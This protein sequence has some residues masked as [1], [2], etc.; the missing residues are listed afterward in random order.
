M[1][2]ILLLNAEI[3]SFILIISILSSF[4]YFCK[5]ELSLYILSIY[6]RARSYLSAS[7]LYFYSST[8]LPSNSKVADNLNESFI[9]IELYIKPPLPSCLLCISI[10]LIFGSSILQ[11]SETTILSALHKNAGPGSISSSLCCALGNR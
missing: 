9:Y 2:S 5:L 7:L 1:F 3:S 8:F 11:S 4:T 6:R 10:I